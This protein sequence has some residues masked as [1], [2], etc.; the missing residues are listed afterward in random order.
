MEEKN[1]L[2][3]SIWTYYDFIL[4]IKTRT[5]IYNVA[6]RDTHLLTFAFDFSPSTMEVMLFHGEDEIFI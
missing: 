5:E 1:S 2:I 3:I 6:I 4:R